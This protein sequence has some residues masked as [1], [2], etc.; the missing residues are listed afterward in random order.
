MEELELIADLQVIE[1]LETEPA[2][3]TLGDLAHIVLEP[4]ERADAAFVDNRAVAQD[5]SARVPGDLSV[6]DVESGHHV[7]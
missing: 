7:A 2:F 6:E 3:V 4:F 5:A 1:R